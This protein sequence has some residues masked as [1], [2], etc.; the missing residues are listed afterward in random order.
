M[1][2][3]VY[4]KYSAKSKMTHTEKLM[5]KALITPTPDSQTED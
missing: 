3:K 2:L 1:Q 5:H 4:N